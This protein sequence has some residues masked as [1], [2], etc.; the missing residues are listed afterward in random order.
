MRK[1]IQFEFDTILHD[2]SQETDD[3]LTQCAAEV[4]ESV[5]AGTQQVLCRIGQ[6]TPIL[7][8]AMSGDAGIELNYKWECSRDGG[9]E[10]AEKL[11]R[12]HKKMEAMT[13][14]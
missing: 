13:C 5:L 8:A 3:D 11:E 2:A 9:S 12:A 10:R 14:A 1:A 4:C 6:K 7:R